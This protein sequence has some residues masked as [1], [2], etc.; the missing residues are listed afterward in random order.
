[1]AARKPASD[2]ADKAPEPKAAPVGRYRVTHAQ[3]RTF[4]ASHDGDRMVLRNGKADVPAALWEG[5]K[6]SNPVVKA[7]LASGA[8]EAI[9]IGE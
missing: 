4:V 7:L 8:I 3:G 2:S 6:A 5:I 9:K 1:M